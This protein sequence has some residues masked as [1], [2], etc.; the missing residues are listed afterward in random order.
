MLA[1][2][3]TWNCKQQW[4]KRGT[5][6]PTL[7]ILNTYGTPNSSSTDLFAS[8]GE[9][10]T[11]VDFPDESRALRRHSGD[12]GSPWNTNRVLLYLMYCL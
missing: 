8:D 3:A 9:H 5:S 11:P 12:A 2:V 10:C 1:I 4:E 6:Q 7:A